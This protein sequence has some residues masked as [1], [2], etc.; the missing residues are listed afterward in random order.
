MFVVGG[1]EAPPAAGRKGLNGKGLAGSLK[2]G[3]NIL[4]A[5][6]VMSE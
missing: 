5:E 3:T 2:F 1:R 6:P 4:G